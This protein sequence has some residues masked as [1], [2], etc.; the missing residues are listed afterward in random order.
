MAETFNENAVSIPIVHRDVADALN[1]NSRFHTAGPY[2]R[3]RLAALV[4]MKSETPH[5]MV[6]DRLIECGHEREAKHLAAAYTVP[7][8]FNALMERLN[9]YA[10]ECEHETVASLPDEWD[11]AF[12]PD[13]YSDKFNP[14]W[15][16]ISRHSWHGRK[17]G[18]VYAVDRASFQCEI[19]AVCEAGI[20]LVDTAGRIEPGQ[21][22][23]LWDDDFGGFYRLD[24]R[25]K[26]M[27]GDSK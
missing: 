3:S 2:A 23:C 10:E 24:Y 7:A 6:I 9:E 17:D 8:R 4:G 26:S 1:D 15:H 13:F 18:I 14:N 11:A 19:G 21:V 22:A 5:Y 16:F 27:D 12:M 25:T 20:H